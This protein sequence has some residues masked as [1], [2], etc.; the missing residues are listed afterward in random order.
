MSN[1]I[2]LNMVVKNHE[3]LIQQALESV[4]ENIGYWVIVD[5]G[6]T[7]FTKAKILET[8]QG[9]PGE[10]V[11]AEFEN[12]SQ[13]RNLAL[14]RSDQK[15]DYILSINPDMALNLPENGID[16][17]LAAD[18]YFISIGDEI[19]R[20][21]L[22]LFKN[23]LPHWRYQG[24]TFEYLASD[25]F[26]NFETLEGVKLAERV[27][28][29][30]QKIELQD[31][32]EVLEILVEE[33]PEDIHVLLYLAKL[34]LQ[35]QELEASLELF[36]RFLELENP[37]DPEW[38]WFALYSTARIKEQLEY[39]MAEISDAY[40]SA[41]QIRPVRAEPLY[42]LARFYRV[43]GLYALACLYGGQ[44]MKMELPAGESFEIVTAIYQWQIPT[45]YALSCAEQLDHCSAIEASNQALRYGKYKRGMRDSL[46]ASRQRSVDAIQDSKKLDSP[47]TE[48][49]QIRVVVPFRNAKEF[50]VTV[51]KRLKLKTIT[52]LPPP[53]SMTV[54]P[55]ILD[56]SC[57]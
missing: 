8:L 37:I 41:F 39:P 4:K 34:K 19:V 43:K 30:N 28:A 7:D 42:E 10:L 40:L 17:E 12:W 15:G 14:D 56:R 21:E 25:K 32:F 5:A 29:H 51:S 50:C 18:A 46:I 1:R 53:L 9:I 47:K 23:E 33:F 26:K 57:R 31:D 36:K 6:T 11:N 44:A 22:R 55:M 13:L 35:A 27:N 52:I 54:L 24:A 45:E 16:S 20:K 49:N 2:C 38:T 3:P 48:T